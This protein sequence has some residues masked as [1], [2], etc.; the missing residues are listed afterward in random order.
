MINE[1]VKAVNFWILKQGT[2]PDT[3]YFTTTPVVRL[4]DFSATNLPVVFRK[5]LDYQ[6]G[7]VFMQQRQ[8]IF[9]T[10]NRRIWIK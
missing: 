5:G 9:D 4:G 7:T 2:K 1:Q 6:L 10:K 3:S 8:W